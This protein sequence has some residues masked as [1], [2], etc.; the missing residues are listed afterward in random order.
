MSL[1]FNMVTIDGKE[2]RRRS[3]QGMF[4][5]D[6][7]FDYLTLLFK[8]NNGK[9]VFFLPKMKKLFFAKRSI[10]LLNPHF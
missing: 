7:K 6:E 1:V 2:F 10:A 9:A 4:L 5:W 8:T 3:L